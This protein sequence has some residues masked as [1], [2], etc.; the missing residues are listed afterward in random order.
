M[1]EITLSE[2]LDITTV[3]TCREEWQK[4]L[5][6]ATQTVRL[7]VDKLNKIDTAG[8]QL[9]VALKKEATGAGKTFSVSG[10][11]EALRN[12]SEILGL[13]SFLF[14]ETPGGENA[15]EAGNGFRETS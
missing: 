14:G 6:A 9:L 4:V 10:H 5:L 15:V 8:L 3:A 12:Q 1:E 11:S 7:A 2:S 13:T